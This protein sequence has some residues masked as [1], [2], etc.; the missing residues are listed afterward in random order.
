MTM[1]GLLAAGKENFAVYSGSPQ[2]F[3]NLV[4]SPVLFWL[5][6]K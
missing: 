2:T 6:T 4:F 3:G 5:L 1:H